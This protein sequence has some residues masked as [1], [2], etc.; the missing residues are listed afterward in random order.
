VIRIAMALFVISAFLILYVTFL[1]P[2]VLLLLRRITRKLSVSGQPNS[3]SDELPHVTVVIAVYNEGEVLQKKLDHLRQLNYPEEKLTFLFGSD[4]ST[5]ETNAI[6]TDTEGKRVLVQLYPE[7]RGKAAVLND[8]LQQAR[9][10]IVVMSD[11]NTFY[12]PDSIQHLVRHFRDP[13]IGAVCGMLT[14]QT[15]RDKT[16]GLGEGT[17]WH[18]DNVVKKLESDI[19]TTI[20]ANGALYA[21]RRRLFQPLPMTKSV[22]DDIHIPL[23]ILSQGFRMIYD[24]SARA[25]EEVSNS[26]S[27]EFRRRS[28]IVARNLYSIS[29]FPALLHPRAGF[30]SFALWSHKILR[31]GIPI[32]MM[33]LF[34]GSGILARFYEIFMLVF[35]IQILFYIAAVAG[36]FMD[37]RRIRAGVFGYPYYFVAM[38]AAIL[39][40]IVSFS[41]GRGQFIWNPVR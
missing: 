35:L 33:L 13:G 32:Y 38:N 17:Y 14:L 1:Y 3:S 23:S 16:G 30:I 31:W 8:L 34:I 6:L 25:Y 20:S 7:R 19:R 9:G 36:Y 26:V 41:L 4:G 27:G 11:A 2:L 22:S 15:D 28:R 12:H 29:E 40:G 37:R 5:D 21:I 10:E 24:S 39:A 18:Y